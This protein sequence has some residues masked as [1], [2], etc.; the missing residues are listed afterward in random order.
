MQNL[1]IGCIEKIRSERSA[2]HKLACIML[3][4][5]LI[6]V[7]C[8]YW[9]LKLTGV[10]LVN[11]Y[12]CGVEEH[13]HTDECY[14]YV[15]A[16]GLE[17]SEANEE[18]ETTEITEANEE[19]DGTAEKVE[20]AEVTGHV[21]TEECYELQLV[22]GLEEHTHS[23][24]CLID[25][26]ADLETAEIWEATLPSLTGVWDDDLILVARSQIGYSESTDNY[27]ISEDGVT[28]KGYT[29]YGEWAGNPYGDWDAMF[30]SFCLNYAG[31]SRDVFPESTGAYAWSVELR[32]MK[33]Y[34]D[35][36]DDYIPEPGS[37]VFFDKDS[38]GKI[39]HVGI[40]SFSDSSVVTVIEGN[41]NDAVWENTY[42]RVGNAAIIGYGILPKQYAAEEIYDEASEDEVTLDD[43][44]NVGM[45]DEST[46]NSDEETVSEAETIALVMQTLT[47]QAD[48]AVIT[49]SGLLPGNA[50]VTAVPVDVEIDG[51]EVLLAFDISI[52]YPDASGEMVVFE[53]NDGAITVTIESPEITGGSDVYYVPDEGE[54]EK[55][56]NESED[57]TIAFD[58]EH[59]STYAVTSS[60]TIVATGT[61]AN[62][63]GVEDAIT[64]TIYED[65]TGARTLVFSG[66]GSIPDYASENAGQPWYSYRSTIG[67]LVLEEGITRVGKQAFHGNYF[68]DIQFA[69][70]VTSIGS[71][72]FSYSQKLE[73]VTIPETITTIESYAFAYSYHIYEVNLSEGLE[74]IGDS[75]FGGNCGSSEDCSETV[76][77]I[78]S[79]VTSIGQYPF[80]NAAR[81]EVADGNT[82]FS[83]DEDGVLYSYDGSILIDYPK[84]RVADSWT[85]PDTV[86]TI[87]QGALQNV[88]NTNKIYVNHQV[89][90]PTQCFRDSNYT[91]VYIADDVTIPT[92]SSL[93]F[94][95]DPY[96]T[97]V[98]L[99]EN[100]KLV[101]NNQYFDSDSQLASLKIPEGTTTINN[102]AFSGTTNLSTLCYDATH[103]TTINSGLFGTS[104]MPM[105][106]LTIGTNVDY[107]V[108]NFSYILAHASSVTIEGPNAFYIEDGAFDNA[109]A[110]Y[111][112]LSGWIYVDENGVIY[113]L[114]TTTNEAT[115]YYVPEDVTELTV[116]ATITDKLDGDTDVTFTVTTVAKNALKDASSLSSVVFGDV[117]NITTLE[118]YALAN[119]PIESITDQAT[120]TTVD[121]ETDAEALF[122]N[123][124]A[125]IGYNAFY[126]TLLVGS[127]QAGNFSE[128][129]DGSK[130]LQVGDMTISV[131]SGNTT[132]WVES[133]SDPDAGGY[134]SLTGDAVQFN[135]AISNNAG[136]D[137][138]YR[139]YIKV[140]DD[141]STLSYTAGNTYN[142][143]GVEV[144]A[145]ATSDPYTICLEFTI[146]DG[147]TQDFT[148]DMVYPSPTSD[149]GGATVW[150]TVVENGQESQKTGKI[151]ACW[152][153]R[154]DS[155]TLNKTNNN[156]SSVAISSSNGTVRPSADVKWQ[157]TLTSD[158]DNSSNGED[159]LKLVTYTDVITLPDGM[160][161]D[162]DILAAI[163]AGTVA[164]RSNVLYAGTT[165]IATLSLGSSTNLSLSGFSISYDDSTDQVVM[166]WKVRNTASSTTNMYTNTLSLSIHPDALTVDMNT[167]DTSA[168]N[169]IENT[170]TATLEY[171]YSSE[172][173]QEK[174]VEKAVTGGEGT[175]KISKTGTDVT[176]F[177]EDLTYTIS[178][179]NNGGLPYNGADS[180]TYTVTD[181]LTSDF[182][183]SPDN[184]E[185]MFEEAAADGTELVITISKATLA[186]GEGSSVT[187]TDGTADAA[188]TN[189]GNSD[190]SSETD[191]NTLVITYDSAT[192]NYTVTVNGNSSDTYIGT[193]LEEVLQSLGYGVTASVT[194]SCVWTLP[195]EGANGEFTLNGGDDYTYNIYSTVKSTFQMLNGS[196]W[197]GEYLKTS[198]KTLTNKAT[199]A[200][201]KT[202]TSAN[203]TNDTVMREAIIGKSVALDGKDLGSAP[204]ASD[205]DV[206]D[207]TLTFNHYGDG[208]YDDLPM[209]DDLYGSQ[210]LL[211][212]ISENSGNSSIFSSSNVTKY[213]ADDD[214]IDDYY[215]LGEGE[216]TDIV[217]CKDTDGNWMTAATITVS[218]SNSEET[219]YINSESY[220]WSGVHTQIKWYFDHLDG[221]NYTIELTY[222]ALVDTSNEASYTIG[223][224]VWMNDRVGSRIYAGLWGGGTIIGFDKDI[225][226]DAY[227]DGDDNGD[228]IDDDQHTTVSAGETVTYRLTLESSGDSGA[229]IL[230]G[231]NIADQ[232]PATYGVF[233]W[234]KD[235]V[236]IVN[237]VVEGSGVVTNAQSLM[238]DNNWSIADSYNGIS[239]TGTWFIVWD[240]DVSVSFSQNTKVYVYVQLTYPDNT[241]TVVNGNGET[242]GMWN[243]YADQA[244]GASISNTFLVYR[245]PSNVTHVL[246]REGEVTLQKGV[247][248]LA[249]SVSSTGIGTSS[250][251]TYYSTG[252]SRQFYNNQDASYRYV[253]YYV[254]IYNDAS[255]RLYLNDLYDD[256]PE[257]FVYASLIPS[258]Y[259]I[260]NL[261]ASNGAYLA[262]THNVTTK[263]SSD[264]WTSWLIQTDSDITYMSAYVNATETSDGNV[265]FSFSS[266]SGTYALKYDDE[267]GQYYLDK[268]E[269]IVFGYIC[270]IGVTADT[271][272]LATN[273]IA[274]SY[275]DYTGAGVTESDK[276]FEARNFEPYGSSDNDGTV[277]IES[278]DKVKNEYGFED[279]TENQRWLVS[280][281]S[282]ERGGI[283]PGVEKD[284][285]SHQVSTSA[286]AEPYEDSVGPTELVNWKVTLTN[287]GDMSII[288]YVITDTMPTPYVFTGPV[289]FVTYDVNGNTQTSG[290]L[291]TINTSPDNLSNLTELNS[292]T[293][294]SLS[295]TYGS[296]T[297]DVKTDGTEYALTVAISN[298]NVK[299]N[300]S[301]DFDTNGNLVMKLDM[302]SVYLSI[303]EGG[304]MEIS[305]TSWN[306]TTTHASTTYINQVTLTP[307]QPFTRSDIQTGSAVTD[308][309]G[310]LTGV[311]ALS[312]VTVATGYATTADKYVTE[313]SSTAESDGSSNNSIA[314]ESLDSEFT[315]TLS[316]RNTNDVAIAN[317]VFIDNLPFAGDT[318]TYN[319][320]M[321]RDS[322]FSVILA[323]TDFVVT[324]TDKQGNVETFTN[325]TD[326]TVEYS[327]T[328]TGNFSVADRNGEASSNWETLTSSTNLSEVK[329]IRV[330][331]K[332]EI[333]AE[334]TVSVSFKAKVSDPDSV[335]PGMVA[336]N[337]FGYRYQVPTA[338]YTE[339]EATTLA[340]GVK[341]PSAPE[342]TKELID[343]ESETHI[344]GEDVRFTFVVYQGEELKN[345][346]ESYATQAELIAALEDAGIEYR[347]V[348]SDVS[349]GG[350]TSDTLIFYGDNGL[351]SQTWWNWV[352]GDSYTIAEFTEDGNYV[353]KEWYEGNTKLTEGNSYTFVYNS[354]VTLRLTC[355]NAYEPWNL[356]LT[357]VEMDDPSVLL[358]GTVFALYTDDEDLKMTDADYDNLPEK[359]DRTLTVGTET[360]YLY[361][362]G[363]T[364]ADGTLTWSDL[365]EDSYYLV[366]IKAPDGYNINSTPQLIERN[367]NSNNLSVTV[368]NK[369]G[370]TMPY[371]GG[372]G[373][374]TVVVIGIIVFAASVALLILKWQKKT[375]TPA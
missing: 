275:T 139:V 295:V 213:D 184:M 245:N 370:Y 285:V 223:N 14:E 352:N 127:T 222:K 214:G 279:A 59:F 358:S 188:Y 375:Q 75:A 197:A 163:K 187:S 90:I 282:L 66:T 37:L 338:S 40:V 177:G 210:Y 78:P 244:Q 93:L 299:F 176:Y 113:T 219:F 111:T 283:S 77:T 309:N 178:V 229:F 240:D 234:S 301:F 249:R 257:G 64:W 162:E 230:T 231:D 1:L 141:D 149:G 60:D 346:G 369:P 211:V 191:D 34:T 115:L 272:N 50:V 49:V 274:M 52:M 99:P 233:N 95:N 92:T 28:L 38:D 246:A 21:H 107:L 284:I 357:K 221:G 175:I 296:T 373:S 205:G 119:A 145:I 364:D 130:T 206:L 348:H 215:I 120:G 303:P 195:N 228:G 116:P 80:A 124:G 302:E 105:F 91:Y 182:F 353:F 297:I 172:Q 336:W 121:S 96:L 171:T 332:K 323:N 304:K 361:G 280:S 185:R 256:L 18:S 125:S 12:Y 345:N 118:A 232:L 271:E 16:C 203:A 150:G 259:N 46:D 248:A 291:F 347:I 153:T 137:K 69:S 212:P 251:T 359:P 374:Q 82:T 32:N 315:Y 85:V 123:A 9:Q 312:P 33:L 88:K 102:L 168:T 128:N 264:S 29:R 209:I 11:E 20:A 169:V 300:L 81:Y 186:I 319:D 100:T 164:C 48:D 104:T 330:I 225:V 160:E 243:E 7:I 19:A 10:A 97:E 62:G 36:N 286:S 51:K 321:S 4:L 44:E 179:Y 266:G 339:M 166:T 142:I 74:T 226:V 86:T 173:T 281:V 73:T 270:K 76:I 83:V 72:A 79:T 140:T 27:V 56:D 250:G 101:I 192:G 208:S 293:L 350:N 356:N 268:G 252:T 39:D 8:V 89:T 237:V 70:T 267:M 114:D 5:S 260:A 324:I 65:D 247:Y 265:T 41:Y 53:P 340:V 242:V 146:S 344:A 189:T 276:T 156:Q 193:S 109:P 194:Y 365:T 355:K 318:L 333:P 204:D 135:F 131:I 35:S 43:E 305:Y 360:W 190:L 200:Y 15:L 6:V 316:V 254:S 159:Y 68:T 287:A 366:E 152:V 269:A 335:N 25:Q 136:A 174:S 292:T 294:P 94:Y 235:N 218:G 329:S 2:R 155:Y 349:E 26:S 320:V 372:M 308:D 351:T 22:C 306:P 261:T 199:L 363:T 202:T 236:D 307:T 227:S 263:S 110:P 23:V 325:G 138:T 341:V 126:N 198:S 133:A 273:T 132:E 134:Q 143:N 207:Y 144:T 42:A 84:R 342:L 314:L 298:R 322:E 327:S 31:I 157:I 317:V 201:G 239:G 368:E 196:D 328:L 277:S 58:A 24:E 165:K 216:Y 63:E 220:T 108:A 17:E 354:A 67:T 154:R 71:Y 180:D 61:I 103:V 337:S 258:S 117:S 224:M 331:V 362:V 112:G 181:S 98:Y 122:T 151:Q 170:A 310:N 57:G 183:I 30:V 238:D 343:L 13:V 148:I 147:A 217:V 47:V 313:G 161:W 255:T 326:Y 241:E 55:L 158:G 288:D 253:F 289:S 87:R 106:D 367:Q 334:A 167:Y 290:T 278:S 129:M 311:S 3:V 371:S 262:C 45:T 54:P